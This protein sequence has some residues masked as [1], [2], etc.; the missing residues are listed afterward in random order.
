ML[1]MMCRFIASK[2][3]HTRDEELY[4]ASK[5]KA[6][7][8]AKAVDD[9]L[10]PL[11]QLFDDFTSALPPVDYMRPSFDSCRSMMQR[12]RTASQPPLPATAADVVI[13]DNLST[14]LAG[15]LYIFLYIIASTS[16][17]CCTYFIVNNYLCKYFAVIKF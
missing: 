6:D 14:T 10:T 3:T 4:Q 9:P 5:L 16:V 7:L 13:P 2:N 15:E 8:C 11:Q 12:A 17:E 1:V